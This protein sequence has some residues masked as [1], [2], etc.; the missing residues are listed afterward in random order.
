MIG[1]VWVFA[2]G[3]PTTPERLTAFV[4]RIGDLQVTDVALML[5]Q[6]TERTFGITTAPARQVEETARRLGSLGVA[7]H[8]VTWLRPDERFVAD[9]A[10]RL[11]PLCAAAGA[12]SLMFDV[13]EPWTTG[14]SEAR[15]RA[16]LARHWP[17][18]GWPCALGATGITYIPPS[19]RPV[20]ERCD[21]VLPQAYSAH[22]QGAVYH[23][24][25]TQ[26]LAH[27]LWK[28]LGKPIVMGLAGWNEILR[29]GGISETE[30]LQRAIV[31]TEG[32]RDP[33][34]TDVAYWVLEGL[35]GER[36][37]FVRQAAA[38]ARRG[39]PQGAGQPVVPPR[40]APAP[41]PPAPARPTLRA[42]DRGPAVRDL[43][44]RIGRAG[45]R[46]AA[47]G[48]FGPATDRAVRAF[49][50]ARGLVA[51]GV[52]GPATWRSLLAS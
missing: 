49:Q 39:V 43:Q 38:K 18:T 40:P 21:Y 36:A 51:D 7:A 16:F 42:G 33:A 26:P 45:G 28:G 29:P 5:N 37:A 4:R 23:P 3:I 19:V 13:E 1:R 9:A 27:R 32:L 46:L 10:H 14:N 52:V 48:V 30:A 17:F 34:I 50:R 35:A 8:L 2:M 12:R 25:A 11:R 22:F 41:A 24:G 20:A 15:A 31:A 47:D 6:Y 44:A